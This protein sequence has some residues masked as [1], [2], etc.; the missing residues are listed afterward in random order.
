MSKS[1]SKSI[2][3]LTKTKVKPV[4]V[5]STVVVAGLI[6]LGVVGLSLL[7][8]IG[9]GAT[10]QI[11]SAAT[12]G[13]GE[14][15]ISFWSFDQDTET[16]AVDSADAN[17]GA[18]YG[19]TSTVEAIKLKNSSGK[20]LDFDNNDFVRVLDSDNLDITGDLTISIWVKRDGRGHAGLVTK[21]PWERTIGDVNLDGVINNDDAVMINDIYL[22]KID[23]SKVPALC[24]ADT[25]GDGQITP[26]DGLLAANYAL[27]KADRGKRTIGKVGRLCSKANNRSYQLLID[28]NNKFKMMISSDGKASGTKSIYSDRPLVAGKWYN[29]VGVKSGD[30]LL[31]YINGQLQRSKAIKLTSIY[32]GTADVFFGDFNTNSKKRLNGTLDEVKI[33]NRALSVEEIRLNINSYSL[34]G[35]YIWCGNVPGSDCYRP[36]KLVECRQAYENKQATL[37]DMLG[38]IQVFNEY[39]DS[40]GGC[41][42]LHGSYCVCGPVIGV[43]CTTQAKL[44]ECVQAYRDKQATMSQMLGCIQVFNQTK[45]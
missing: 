11:A 44:D 43:E 18:I 32:A 22:A 26:G 31:L 10:D 23:R 8:I 13:V 14:D 41:E 4:L 29:V 40:K 1:M 33:Y 27:N 24:A 39:V 21:W 5:I 12:L 20:A 28:D 17:N 7:D 19:A 30:K 35:S 34:H 16:T 38:C 3:I 36:A 6:S 9:T 42:K 45:R 2:K 37:S 15:P 25:N